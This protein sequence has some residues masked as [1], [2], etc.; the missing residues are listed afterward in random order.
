MNEIFWSYL[1]KFIIVF[2]DDILIYNNTLSD[3]LEEGI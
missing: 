3:H 1:R 2:F